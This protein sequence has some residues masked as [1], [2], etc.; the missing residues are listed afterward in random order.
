MAI[1]AARFTERAGSGSIWRDFNESDG[2]VAGK[3]TEAATHAG[4][5]REAAV[6]QRHTL[7]AAPMGGERGRD[8]IDAVNREGF[9]CRRQAGPPNLGCEPIAGHSIDLGGRPVDTLL[10]ES[11][12]DLHDALL[13]VGTHRVI[14]SEKSRLTGQKKAIPT[15]HE[16]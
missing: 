5:I 7:N 10:V 1:L 16:R 12:D 6:K 9:A 2:T 4:G 14:L 13:S 11:T 3:R 15:S 8:R